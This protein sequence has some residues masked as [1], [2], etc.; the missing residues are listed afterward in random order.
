MLSCVFSSGQHL[1]EEYEQH[2]ADEEQRHDES[3]A[4]LEKRSKM[5]GDVKSG[6]EHLAEKLRTLKMVRL[7]S[8]ILHLSVLQFSTMCLPTS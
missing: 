1:L 5:F 3:Q 2:L 4:K 7:F 8:L 6:V